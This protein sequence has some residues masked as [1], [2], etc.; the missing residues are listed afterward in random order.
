LTLFEKPG[1]EVFIKSRGKMPFLATA[2]TSEE[3]VEWF[4]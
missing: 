1:R 4:N 2:E 3:V